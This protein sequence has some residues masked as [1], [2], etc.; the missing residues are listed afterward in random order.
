ML[1]LFHTIAKVTCMLIVLSLMLA[2]EKENAGGSDCRMCHLSELAAEDCL[3][4]S[5]NR[6]V[7]HFDLRPRS[8]ETRQKHLDILA[9]WLSNQRCIS[10]TEVICNSC[11]YT[12]PPISEI[13]VVS[14]GPAKDSLILDVRMSTPLAISGVHYNP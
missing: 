1:T 13:L 7:L 5:L 8:Q 6:H 2:C 11:V 4:E 14:N 9:S 12:E 10:S 3:V